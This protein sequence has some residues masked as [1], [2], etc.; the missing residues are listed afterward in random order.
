MCGWVMTELNLLIQY[1]FTCHCFP[2][3]FN[4]S[5]WIFHLLF[6]PSSLFVEKFDFF[7]EFLEQKLDSCDLFAHVS[8]Q[9]GRECIFC[10]QPCHE[11]Q[12]SLAKVNWLGLLYSLGSRMIEEANKFSSC[13][14]CQRLLG[15]LA[16][17]NY[18]HSSTQDTT[19][20][21]PPFTSALPI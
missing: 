11:S 7:P 13:P 16:D 6:K 21:W 4:L 8:G 15:M 12:A 9:S 14:Y 1:N 18:R 5:V 3:H 20:H 2:I 10:S 17:V 19:Q